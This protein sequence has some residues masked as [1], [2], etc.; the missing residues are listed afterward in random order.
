MKRLFNDARLVPSMQ[1]AE[2]MMRDREVDGI[3]RMRS[4]FATDLYRGQIATGTKIRSQ[5][6][7]GL[8]FRSLGISRL[9]SGNQPV[10]L[11]PV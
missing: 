1:P 3:I 5:S 8:S 11:P 2:N 4:D 6:S 7:D 10:R 9:A